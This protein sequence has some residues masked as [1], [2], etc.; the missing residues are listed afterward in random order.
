MTERQVPAA[1]RQRETGMGGR[2]LQVAVSDNRPGTGPCARARKGADAVRWARE[3]KMTT[4]PEPTDKLD[5]ATK[6]VVN[7]QRTK[8]S[9]SV[10]GTY[11]VAPTDLH[12][13][14]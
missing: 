14:A 7:D 2:L 8:R 4:T 5:A 12:R 13:P 6:V 10:S 1:E 9:L 11:G 3:E